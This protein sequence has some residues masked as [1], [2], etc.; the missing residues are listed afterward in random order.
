MEG[1]LK[2]LLE[3]QGLDVDIGALEKERAE[4]P[5]MKDIVRL[6]AGQQA[7]EK[8]LQV[9]QGELE[10]CRKQVRKYELDLARDRDEQQEL[11]E[12]LYSGQVKNARELSQLEAKVKNLGERIDAGEEKIL[13]VMVKMEDLEMEKAQGEEQFRLI[14]EQLQEKLAEYQHIHL[15]LTKGLEELRSLRSE[16]L[17]NIPADLLATYSRMREKKRGPVIVGVRKGVCQG[18]QVSLSPPLLNM[19]RKGEKVVF[20]ESCGRLLCPLD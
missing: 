9:L 6:K 8:R 1:S 15:R 17:A 12:R 4:I 2:Q 7:I 13:D 18:C 10:E 14:Q 20:C 11:S 5:G 16:L 3:L 19:L